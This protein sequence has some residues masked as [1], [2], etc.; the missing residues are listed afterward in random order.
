ML[1]RFKEALVKEINEALEKLKGDLAFNISAPI[2]VICRDQGK[3][4]A[5]QELLLLLDTIEK[6]ITTGE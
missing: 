2:D 5:L 6:E 4:L 1:A 3:C